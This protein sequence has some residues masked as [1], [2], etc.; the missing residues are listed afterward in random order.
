MKKEILIDENLHTRY[1]TMNSCPCCSDR[2]LRHVRKTEV[3][4]FCRNC[5]QVMPVLR[6]KKHVAALESAQAISASS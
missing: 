5:R 1:K 3:Y 4:W 6:N 2:L